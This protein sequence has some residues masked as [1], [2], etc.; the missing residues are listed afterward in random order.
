MF[1]SYLKNFENDKS[2]LKR[3]KNN[4]NEDTLIKKYNS[5]EENDD[6][7]ITIRYSK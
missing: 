4:Q 1:S 6:S 3:D 7:L 2:I 5:V